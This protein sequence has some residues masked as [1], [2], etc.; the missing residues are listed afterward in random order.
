[1]S[2]LEGVQ[3]STAG[4]WLTPDG[5]ERLQKE[6]EML[7]TQKR[8]EIAERLR[9]SKEH[10][11]FS[12]DNHELDEVKFEQAYVENRI[13]DL[14]IIFAGAQIIDFDTLPTDEAGVGNYVTVKDAERG[15]EFE[16]RLVSS[17]EADPDRDYV[18]TESPM[19]LAI[20]GAKVGDKVAFD[21]PAGKIQ[22]EVTQI[23]K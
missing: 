19:G 5:Y 10:G 20:V 15:V 3:V 1:M 6:L 21:A 9:D 14:K 8:A 4:V 12:E 13:N 18:S 7:T 16:I 17:I 11:E 22:Y 2:E 23:R